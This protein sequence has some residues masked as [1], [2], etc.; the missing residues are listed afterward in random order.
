MTRLHRDHGQTQPLSRYQNQQKKCKV[1]WWGFALFKNYYIMEKLSFYRMPPLGWL[2]RYSDMLK[3]G[4]LWVLQQCARAS[5]LC[6]CI[7]L[8]NSKL[9]KTFWVTWGERAARRLRIQS[10]LPEAGNNKSKQVVTIYCKTF[11][12][13]FTA[14]KNYILFESNRSISIIP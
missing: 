7:L 12:G 13:S 2:R 9:Y 10:S 14:W 8:M 6:R 11:L 5:N 1:Y 4:G 3:G